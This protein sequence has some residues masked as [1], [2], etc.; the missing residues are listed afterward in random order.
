MEIIY[1]EIKN[2]DIVIFGS[3]VYLDGITAQLKAVID[4][5]V[6]CMEPFLVADDYGFT[7]HSFA[8][9]L[10]E[11]CIVVSTCGFPE[12]ETFDPVIDYFQALSRNVGS[13]VRA[14]FCVSGSIAIQ[15]KPEI[16]NQKLELLEYAGYE[17]G[18]GGVIEDNLI[19]KI[20]HP[21]FDKDEYFALARLYEDRC[22]KKLSGNSRDNI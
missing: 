7:R 9:H 14:V 16:L 15:M 13:R 10:P 11:E 20:N 8:W 18:K 5:L 6:C 2:S 3:P 21:L 17:Y 1:N 4:R 22:R 19:E 12:S